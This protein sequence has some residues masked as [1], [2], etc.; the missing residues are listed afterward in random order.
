[1]RYSAFA[2]ACGLAI[3]FGLGACGDEDDDHGHGGDVPECVQV[4]EAC[5]HYDFGATQTP[6][7]HECHTTAEKDDK[8]ACIAQLAQC[9]ALCEAAAGRDGGT[10]ATS[11]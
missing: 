5:H 10:D 2:S 6:E 1:L 7:I 4:V 9:L 8:D 11:D 3:L